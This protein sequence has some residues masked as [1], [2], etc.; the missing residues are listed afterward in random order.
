VTTHDVALAPV[1]TWAQNGSTPAQWVEVPVR[2]VGP[3]VVARRYAALAGIAVFVGALH[4]AHR[5][6][7]ICVFRALTGLPCPLCG[8]TTAAVHLGHADIR[9]AVAA[10]PLAVALFAT[11]PLLGAFRAPR[12]WHRRRTRLLTIVAV[13]VAAEV[14]QLARFGFIHV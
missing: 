12:W 3:V 6:A 2:E 1:A 11:G 14:W 5:P 7:T 13:L 4:I 10:S 8:G 9:G